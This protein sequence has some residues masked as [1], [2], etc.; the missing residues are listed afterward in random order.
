MKVLTKYLNK[1]AIAAIAK[2]DMEPRGL[3][4][5]SQAGNHKSPFQGFSVE[6]AGHREYVPGDDIKHIDWNVFYKKDKYFIKQYEAETNLVCQ[7]FLD[8]S[9]S[10][11]FGSHEKT[12]L[13]F[14]YE[15][16]VCLTY[17]VTKASDKVGCCVFDETILQYI[18]PSN[19]LATV[20]KLNSI[21][22]ETKA[23]KKTSVEK[24]LMDFAERLGRREIVI[25]ISD[26][27]INPEELKRGLGRLRYDNHE[28]VLFHMIDPYEKDFPMD[29]RI[30]FIGLE[31]FP[32]LKLQPRQIRKAY[33]EK[34]NNHRDKIVEICEKNRV[35]Y[36]EVD[37]SKPLAEL[38]FQYMVSRLTHITR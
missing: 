26:F 29:G 2:M 1:Q 18:R 38:M 25:L 10:M 16:A 13:D 23:T 32:E 17:L 21:L 31:G 4:A 6:F 33:L 15:L 37:T 12:K 7:I 24:N 8:V 36:V 14:A 34:F 11:R 28:I 30:K 9:E 19:S 3:V 20:Y 27:L 22:E 5:G 35:E